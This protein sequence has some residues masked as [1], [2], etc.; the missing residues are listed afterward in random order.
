[1]YTHPGGL[2]MLREKKKELKYWC[3]KGT[4]FNGKLSNKWD[5][6]L[7]STNI[8]MIKKSRYSRERVLFIQLLSAQPGANEAKKQSIAQV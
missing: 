1:M 3:K 5:I 4:Q 7:K 2:K 6:S 8:D